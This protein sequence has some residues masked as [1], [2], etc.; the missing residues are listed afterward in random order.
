MFAA[1]FH[2]HLLMPAFQSQSHGMLK[3]TSHDINA[4][5]LR[6]VTDGLVIGTARPIH[7]GRTTQVWEIRIEDERARLVCISRLTVAVV[8]RQ[9]VPH[10]AG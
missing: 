9:V 5:H 8:P 10:S 3:R 7:V 4:N 1:G 2:S 6:A